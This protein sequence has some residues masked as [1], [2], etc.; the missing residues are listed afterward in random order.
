VNDSLFEEIDHTADWALQVSGADFS[1][2]LQNAA[3]GMLKLIRA[4]AVPGP[5]VKKVIHLEASDGESLLVAWLEELLFSMEVH[6]VTYTSFDI[7]VDGYTQLK[8]T[9]YEAPLLR[10]EKEIKAVTYHNLKIHQGPAGFN[11]TI[12]FDV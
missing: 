4:E 8:A 10:L 1:A 11:T 2:L 6:N 7:Q 12:V 9:V 5:G 3:M